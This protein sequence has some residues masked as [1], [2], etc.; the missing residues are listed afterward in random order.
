MVLEDA[1]AQ[2]LFVQSGSNW[3]LPK[4]SHEEG[5]WGQQPAPPHRPTNSDNPNLPGHMKRVVNMPYADEYH[6]MGMYSGETNDYGVPHGR[7]RMKYDDGETL[8]GKW[9]NGAYLA[10]LL[11][12]TH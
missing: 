10:V 4:T 7:G 6:D 12:C 3:A 5:S 2:L 1:A 9:V 11:G 8:E